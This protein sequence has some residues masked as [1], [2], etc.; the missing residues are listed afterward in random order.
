LGEQLR[1][2]LLAHGVTIETGTTVR[3]I[4]AEAGRVTGV[5]LGDG[6]VVGASRVII[7]A[8][9]WSA[10]LGSSCG[11]PLPVAPHRRHLVQLATDAPLDDAAP[12]SWS[13]SSGMYL[14]REG[15]GVLACPGDHAPAEPGY[16]AVDPAMVERLAQTLPEFAPALRDARVHRAWACL[17]TMSSD[18]EAVIGTDPRL[19]GLCWV[20]ALGGFGM[21]AGLG[22]AQLLAEELAGRR[23]D[24]SRALSPSRFC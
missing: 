13:L 7:A 12:V 16:P 6:N 19:D 4:V 5:Q 24:L 14:R 11:C 8:G 3:R 23:S 18:G 1:L 21:T 22:A 20:T 17:R 10:Q 2:R 15:N 9:A